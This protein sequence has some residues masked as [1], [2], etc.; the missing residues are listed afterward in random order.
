MDHFRFRR[1]SNV[2]RATRGALAPTSTAAS[3]RFPLT[4]RIGAA[5]RTRSI[6]QPRM[7]SSPRPTGRTM[8]RVK[9]HPGNWNGEKL[10]E[11]LVARPPRVTRRSMALQIYRS[12]SRSSPRDRPKNPRENRAIAVIGIPAW[13]TFGQV[14]GTKCNAPPLS[15]RVMSLARCA[16]AV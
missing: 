11:C 14:W 2:A 8:S 13:E 16:R 12:R 1:P 5:R 6:A 3:H 9:G 7:R 10:G 15:P 4:D